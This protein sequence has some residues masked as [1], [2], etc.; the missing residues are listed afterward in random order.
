MRRALN[1]LPA[2]TV[3]LAEDEGHLDLLAWL[4]STG[5]VRGQRQR[6]WTP[7]Q[8]QRR[9]LFGALDIRAGAWWELVARQANSR[10]FIAF[11]EQLLAGHPRP[12]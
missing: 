9:T 7:G 5:I 3:I 12:R 11:L 6:L 2:N 8:N 1:Q 4:R 10:E